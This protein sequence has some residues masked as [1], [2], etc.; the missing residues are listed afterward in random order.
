[1][2]GDSGIEGESAPVIH[3]FGHERV[4]VIVLDNLL[5][6]A[7]QL[8]AD[9][10]KAH[11]VPPPGGAYP[12]LNASLPQGYVEAIVAQMRPVLEEVYGLPG[13]MAVELMGYFGLATQP[14]TSLAPIQTVPHVDSADSQQ[15]AFV[16]Y[17]FDRPLGGT[18][19]FR[20]DKTGFETVSAARQALFRETV[21]QELKHLVHRQHVSRQT[22]GYTLLG[23]VAA[24]FNRLIIYPSNL[25]HSGLINGPFSDNPIDGR[26]T[27]NCFV[28]PIRNREFNCNINSN[29][30]NK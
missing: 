7:M 15:L 28:R 2:L 4:P 21:T 25:L 20:H 18:G 17:L 26:L 6:D 22:E 11:F 29:C 30:F 1:M 27:A 14:P 12:G 5:Q 10:A 16:H 8:I 3:R 24:R 19:F 13:E 9:A 23:E